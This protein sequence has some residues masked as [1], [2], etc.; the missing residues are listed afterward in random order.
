MTFVTAG[1]GSGV[2]GEAGTRRRVAGAA[3]RDGYV[4]PYPNGNSGFSESYG[5][6][7]FWLRTA[8]IDDGSS[9]GSLPDG[10]KRPK[11]TSSSA[12]SFAPKL[13]SSAALAAAISGKTAGRSR[14]SKGIRS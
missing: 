6:S 9:N 4:R 1:H 7:S 11:M 13:A 8:S 12:A 14:Y 2:T 5:T 10:A 3:H